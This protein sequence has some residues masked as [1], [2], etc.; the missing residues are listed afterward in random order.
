LADTPGAR[1][2]VLMLLPPRRAP[3]ARSSR[4]TIAAACTRFGV[5]GFKVHDVG[6]VVQGVGFRV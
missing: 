5:T 2:R 1:V 6:C 3:S 4:A